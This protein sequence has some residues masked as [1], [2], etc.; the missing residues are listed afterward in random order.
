MKSQ[1]I[2]VQLLFF[3][4]YR[5]S[6]P[7]PSLH[8]HP[9]P[10]LKWCDRHSTAVNFG[11]V[12][13]RWHHFLCS[14]QWFLCSFQELL[15]PCPRRLLLWDG[16]TPGLACWLSDTAPFSQWPEFRQGQ[17]AASLPFLFFVREL[18]FIGIK[19]L[20]CC[21]NCLL[22]CSLSVA[23]CYLLLTPSFLG[24]LMLEPRWVT[25]S[26]WSFR[27]LCSGYL[28]DECCHLG[29]W[30]SGL[31]TGQN[32]QWGW[33]LNPEPVLGPQPILQV[34]NEHVFH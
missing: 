10:Y 26:K 1:A 20:W 5:R 34:C 16:E 30:H 3:M 31:A 17:V 24:Q 18:C 9:H 11:G 27:K 15:M 19:V 23:F 29:K 2:S 32:P 13:L 4:S 33:V 12:F 14:R 28:E 22:L 25:S 8:P 7:L 21:A 6:R